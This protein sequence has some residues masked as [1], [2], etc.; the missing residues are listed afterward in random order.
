MIL[1]IEPDTSRVCMGGPGKST[2]R[3][4]LHIRDITAHNKTHTSSEAACAKSK[5]G[6]VRPFFRQKVESSFDQNVAF[7]SISRPRAG[8]VLLLSPL[9]LIARISIR[10]VRKSPSLETRRHPSLTP[11]SLHA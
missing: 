3:A 7:R 1:L 11:N 6:R 10:R 9:H 8:R 4:N 5:R 2:V